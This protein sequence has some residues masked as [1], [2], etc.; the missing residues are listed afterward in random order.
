MV[1]PFITNKGFYEVKTISVVVLRR[2]G[3]VLTSRP[4]TD[5]E[6]MLRLSLSPPYRYFLSGR[7]REAN[8]FCLWCLST[9]GSLN[10]RA[11]LPFGTV[12]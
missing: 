4:V 1:F 2:Q 10:H 6:Q 9:Q 8:H 7:N 3:Y 11:R 12:S 5:N